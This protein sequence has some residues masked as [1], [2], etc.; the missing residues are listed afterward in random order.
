MVTLGQG[1]RTRLGASLLFLSL[2]SACALACGTTLGH[3]R[4]SDQSL[5]VQGGQA[6]TAVSSLER[7][8][9]SVSYRIKTFIGRRKKL[10]RVSLIFRN[11]TD[12]AREIRPRVRLVDRTGKS[13]NKYTLATFCSMVG[14]HYSVSTSRGNIQAYQLKRRYRIAPGGTAIGELV[15]HNQQATYPLT[16]YVQIGR[17]TFEFKVAGPRIRG[18]DSVVPSAWC[19]DGERRSG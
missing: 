2:L 5:V 14:A 8:G 11:H 15:F 10:I 1:K 17:E 19:R 13:L 18:G 12:S 4:M 16:L 7:N 6:I 9:L 3:A